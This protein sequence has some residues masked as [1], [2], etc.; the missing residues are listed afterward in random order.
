MNELLETYPT[1][2]CEYEKKNDIVTVYYKESK[3][4]FF[5]LFLSKKLREKTHQIDLDKIGSFIWE[6]CD[7]KS[8]V[9][10]IIE[11]ARAKFL[12]EIEPAEERVTLFIKQLTN[13]K[14]V[15]L[16]KKVS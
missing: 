16:Y 2:L 5:G 7:G 1:R 11:K 4:S 15:Q 10:L 14:L 13:T 12:E 6:E 8:S 3:P 9:N